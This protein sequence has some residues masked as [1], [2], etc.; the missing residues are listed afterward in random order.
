MSKSLHNPLIRRYAFTQLRKWNIIS[1]LGIYF[2]IMAMIN[3][4]CILYVYRTQ[5]SFS[6]IGDARAVAELAIPWLAGLS[7]L[8]FWL[9]ASN[10]PS[11]V[12]ANQA[13]TGTQ[14]FFDL[15]P[16]TGKQKAIGLLIGT[17]LVF[18]P[19]SALTL[20]IA[21]Q[22][23]LVSGMSFKTMLTFLT[24]T[25]TTG[26]FLNTAALLVTTSSLERITKLKVKRSNNLGSGMGLVV[27]ILI[28]GGPMLAGAASS[29]QSA[30]KLATFPIYFFS[31]KLPLL[32][33]AAL[34]LLVLSV[35]CFLGAARKLG[36]PTV[37]VFSKQG[38]LLFLG[39]F[40]TVALGLCW[41]KMLLDGTSSRTFF[42]VQFLISAAMVFML[43]VGASRRSK[44]I[45]EGI[46]ALSAENPAPSQRIWKTAVKSN[47]I[48]F[49]LL[50]VLNLAP[51]ILLWA[52]ME[53]PLLKGILLFAGFAAFFSWTALAWELFSLFKTEYGHKHYVV[54]LAIALYLIVPFVAGVISND[55]FLLSLNPF[56]YAFGMVVERLSKH[57]SQ[58]S[59]AIQALAATTLATTALLWIVCWKYAS[60]WRSRTVTTADSAAKGRAQ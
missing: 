48:L 39:M 38:A 27:L 59:I 31:H 53:Y 58:E 6:S 41:N 17:N 21:A 4:F 12:L 16:L 30:D 26:L 32:N 7:A 43:G 25:V 40:Q 13:A 37:P 18:Y 47:A 1:V 54:G 35:W 22:Y 57:A 19:L 9:L 34:L 51:N 23:A 8:V 50:A 3:C 46:D 5:G 14:C 44:D 36:N 15:L 10:A 2:A 33:L 11:A 49:A 55:P 52:W 20:L 24:F 60:Y 42:I 45:F 28:I 29:F 56:G